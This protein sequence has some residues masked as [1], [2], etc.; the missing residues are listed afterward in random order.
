[1]L[2]NTE[3]NGQSISIRWRARTLMGAISLGEGRK[4]AEKETMKNK[5]G[6]KKDKFI[7]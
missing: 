2:R 7:I 3:A 1:M 4:G 6:E 5:K